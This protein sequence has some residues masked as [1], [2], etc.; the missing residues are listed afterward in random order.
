MKPYLASLINAIIL[1]ILG[2]WAYLSSA[3]P[4]PTA[5][6]P[7]AAGIILLVLTPAFKKGNKIVAHIAVTLTFILL[8]AFIKPLAGGIERSDN[9]AVSRIVIMMISSLFALIIFVRSF[10]VARVKR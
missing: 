9:L 5:L 1:I 8:I 4:S 10:V 3:S 6:I 2:A 7:V